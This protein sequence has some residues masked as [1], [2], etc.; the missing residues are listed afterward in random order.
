MPKV[1]E[2]TVTIEDK[3]G[4]LGRFFNALAER[5][6]NV[7]AFQSFVD[8]GESLARLVVDDPATAKGVLGRLGMIYEETEAVA[9]RL[10]HCPG[11]LARAAV[12][13]GEMNVNVDYSYCGL[14]PGSALAFVVFGVD[15]LSKAARGLDAMGAQAAA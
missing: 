12:L 9:T 5:G 11:E 2:F 15:N 13:L 10:E 14:E 8:E 6:V 3:P 1:K 4:A 7:L